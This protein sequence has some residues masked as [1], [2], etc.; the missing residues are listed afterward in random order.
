MASGLYDAGSKDSLVKVFNSIR[1]EHG[2]V[3]V[4]LILIHKGTGSIFHG[5]KP[6]YYTIK[7]E[8]FNKWELI[9]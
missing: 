5:E 6:R 8:T 7:T 9:S 2:F 1:L 4:K 3:K